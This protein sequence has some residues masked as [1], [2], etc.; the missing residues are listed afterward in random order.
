M[1]MTETDVHQ[2]A[3]MLS[4]AH[5]TFGADQLVAYG[6]TM[7]LKPGALTDKGVPLTGR[8]VAALLGAD[9]NVFPLAVEY[10][11]SASNALSE[12]GNDATDNELAELEAMLDQ[13][14]DG[15]FGVDQFGRRTRLKR[16][17]GGG[18]R[19]QRIRKKYMTVVARFRKCQTLLL[20]GRGYVRPSNFLLPFVGLIKLLGKKGT[21][22]EA[23]ARRCDR[24]YRH[25]TAVWQKMQR[26]GL[27]TQ[28]LPSP[29]QV[30][31]GMMPHQSAPKQSYRPQV[32]PPQTKTVYVDRPVYHQ[33]P[34]P[35]RAPLP[36]Q[37][38]Q[39]TP[40][41]QAVSP[42][43]LAD[44]AA[45]ER[46]MQQVTPSWG[47]DQNEFACDLRAE[48]FGYAYSGVEH[49]YYGIGGS[50][51]E[52]TFADDDDLGDD[53]LSDLDV[54]EL[55]DDDDLFLGEPGSAGLAIP[56]KEWMTQLLRQ[57][58][59]SKITVYKDGRIVADG[60]TVPSGTSLHERLTEEAES[61]PSSDVPDDDDDLLEDVMTQAV[62]TEAVEILGDDDDLLG[63]EDDLG[64][65]DDDLMGLEGDDDLLEGSDTDL[66]GG[67]D[68]DDFGDEDLFDEDDSDLLNEGR[69]PELR[70]ASLESELLYAEAT[71]L[72]SG[73]SG[74]L[75]DDAAFDDF[76]AQND[77]DEEEG[78]FNGPSVKK[79]PG[80]AAKK[81]NKKRT[82]LAAKYHETSCPRKR[83]SIEKGVSQIDA[84]LKSAT[85]KSGIDYTRVRPKTPGTEGAPVVVIAVRKRPSDTEVQARKT[86]VQQYG[87]SVGYHI[88]DPV[89]LDVLGANMFR[90]STGHTA[91][92]GMLALD[93]YTDSGD[94]VQGS[95][96]VFPVGADAPF[97]APR[98]AGDEVY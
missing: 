10:G 22:I 41:S 70:K 49:D 64:G 60:K 20:A 37:Y 96:D 30:K 97:P 91:A 24:M 16:P 47:A 18:R 86:A 58:P 83:A 88:S 84:R 87:A 2:V 98:A 71:P 94:W 34:Q 12:F 77:V 72:R 62:A 25:L 43:Y 40:T 89:L 4:G 11:P 50:D 65:D 55:E 85:P 75:N 33:Q 27:N 19:V 7:I 3:G 17:S 68:D 76:L 8:Q 95:A 48:S 6:E 82:A 73:F 80:P 32:R 93:Q 92:Q 31:R 51:V 14:P 59:P 23:R 63:D 1:T 52:V 13:E 39:Y 28:G 53:G 56:A 36:H 81:L 35:S 45:L 29:E 26:K 69:D 61:A 67:D 15:A 78:S 74:F 21:K 5:G 42:Y 57:G 9:Y 46:E 44:Q 38:P 54:V 90:A 79:I 66:L